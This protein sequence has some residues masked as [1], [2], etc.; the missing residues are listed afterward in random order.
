MVLLQDNIFC[1]LNE[2]NLLK[3][4]SVFC[5]WNHNLTVWA[6]VTNNTTT[7]APSGLLTQ[8]KFVYKTL[9]LLKPGQKPTCLTG[10]NPNKSRPV[11]L[12]D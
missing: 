5:G 3:I 4:R 10:L 9:L 11:S 7:L 8:G 12:T 1:V 2:V 6:T